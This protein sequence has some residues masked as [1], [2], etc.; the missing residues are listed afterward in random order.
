MSLTQVKARNLLD[1]ISKKYD[2]P[3]EQLYELAGDRVKKQNPFASPAAEDFAKR[4][5][6]NVSTLKPS[7]KT[8]KITIDDIRLAIG[9]ETKRKEENLFASPAAKKLADE[10]NLTQSDFSQKERT[11]KRRKASGNRTISVEDVRK[12]LGLEKK[13]PKKSAKKKVSK[14]SVKDSDS[15]SSSDSSSSS[16]DEDN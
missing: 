8:G 10:N 11:G 1:D 14:R 2:I 6:V 5:G 9:E 3:I 4:V 15:E 12:K 13:T 16:S 7:G